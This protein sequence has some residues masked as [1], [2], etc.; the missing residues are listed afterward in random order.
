MNGVSNIA[1]GVVC[2]QFRQADI[3]EHRYVG[4]RGVGLSCK[5]NDRQPHPKR[6]AGGRGAVIGEGIQRDIHTTEG[7]QIIFK[8]QPGQEDDSLRIYAFVI[9]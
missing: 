1:I 3:A 4:A 2:D 6:K 5:H 8:R 7:S 9:K